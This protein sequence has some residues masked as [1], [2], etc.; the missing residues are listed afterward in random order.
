MSI[1]ETI[2]IYTKIYKTYNFLCILYNTI[3]MKYKSFWHQ[4]IIHSVDIKIDVGIMCLEA[5]EDI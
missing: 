4:S 2:W 5:L 3:S 1:S